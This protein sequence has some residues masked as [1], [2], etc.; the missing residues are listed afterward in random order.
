MLEDIE[1]VEPLGGIEPPAIVPQPVVTAGR[2][3]ARLGVVRTMLLN[4]RILRAWRN[5]TSPDVLATWYHQA[6][7]ATGSN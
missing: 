4:Q 5:G 1:M 2:R 7:P 6:G 3:W